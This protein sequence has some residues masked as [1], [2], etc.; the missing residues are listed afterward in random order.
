[1]VGRRKPF[2]STTFKTLTI[3]IFGVG[4]T[5]YIANVGDKIYFSEE[6]RPYTIQACDKRYII[7]TKPF[8]LK[9]TVQYTIVDLQNEIRGADNYWKWGG[10]VDYKDKK[11]CKRMLQALHGDCETESKPIFISYNNRVDLNITKIVTKQNKYGNKIKR[12]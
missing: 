5:I 1:M 3:M 7:C 8:N 11:E 10:F 4:N 6:K 9:H 12:K 2:L